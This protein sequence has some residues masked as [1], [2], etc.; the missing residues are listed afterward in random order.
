MNLTHV[1]FGHAI[2]YIYSFGRRSVVKKTITYSGDKNSLMLNLFF[3]TEVINKPH[4]VAK[5]ATNWEQTVCVCQ[6][7]FCDPCVWVLCVCVL[8]MS[9]CCV[10]VFLSCA[11]REHVLVCAIYFFFIFY[12]WYVKWECIYSPC[13]SYF[14][15]INSMCCLYSS[16]YVS[17]TA[18][19]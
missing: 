19:L 3:F 12:A 9:V 16:Q 4:N 7:I 10:P 15:S 17:R 1:V 2:Y 6:C 8:C 13:Y 5:A 18:A 11:P 14:R